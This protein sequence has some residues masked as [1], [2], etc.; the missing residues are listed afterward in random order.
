M[1]LLKTRILI[2]LFFVCIAPITIAQELDEII[3]KHIEAHGGAENWNAVESMKISGRFTA[4]SVEEDFFAFKTAEGAYY[5]ELYLGQHKV[6]EAFDGQVGWTIDPWQDFTFPRE[7]N[8]LEVNVFRQKSE[9]F[10]PLF[11]YKER[12]IEVE[13]L[14]EQ[15]V[16]G[17]DVYAIKLTRPDG[18]METWYLDASTFLEYKYESNWVDFA[19]PAPA[20]C[21]FDDFR[22]IK[23]LVIP[24]FVERTFFQRDRILQIESI[25]FN[26][27]ID[28][29]LFII[30]RNE[31]MKRLS[32]L[33]GEW[34]VKV[35]VWSRRG[36]R[37]YTVDSTVSKIEFVATN[38]FQEKIRYERIF[39]QSKTVDYSFNSETE[40]YRITV[41]NEFGSDIDVY[42]GNFTD[43][44]FAVS[45]RDISFGGTAENNT[46]YKIIF[47]NIEEDSFEI[48]TKIS[49]NNG[50]SWA[51]VE[52]L[53]YTRREKQ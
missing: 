31:E 23:G 32:F 39:V 44:T 13:L 40:K 3:A 12:G 21:Y 6:I 14:G 30:P 34:D 24:H 46:L 8:R 52:K 18:N 4:F 48:K 11:N 29:D 36:T 43:S 50:E 35:D 41:F 19:Y 53:Q 2:I 20:E 10:T 38:L 9:F 27:K 49:N 37:W 42:E 51:P 16:D 25:D 33:A 17:I 15:D 28:E 26:P 7:L 45:N 5:S 1:K 47:N 22:T